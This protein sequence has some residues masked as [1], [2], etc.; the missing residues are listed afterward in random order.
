MPNTE[1]LIEEP[2]I[3]EAPVEAAATDAAEAAAAAAPGVVEPGAP[4]KVITFAV[5]CYNSAKDMDHCITSIL[6]GANYAEDIEIVIVDDG[7]NKDETPE[8]ADEWA[9]RHPGLIRAV[10][11]ENGG[12]GIAVLSGLRE[13][14]GTY[15][16]VVDSDDWLDAA[17]LSA[18][19]TMLRGFEERGTR[20]DLFISNYVYEKVY[21]GTRNAVSYK[22]VLPTK[23]IF[24]WGEIGRFH[25][26]QNLLM[27]ALCYRTDV[28]RAADVPLP[29]HTFYVDNI[30][31]YT[32]L[33]HCKTV[34]YAD[35]DLY[36]YFIGREGQSVNESTMVKRLDQQFR[37]TYI[38]MRAYH[39]YEDVE[40]EKLRAYMLNYFTMML[41]I[42]TVFS[43]L[44]DDP[45]MPGK[46][47]KL[48]DDLRDFDERM[49][50]KC[51]YSFLGLGTH[52]PTKAG[53]AITVQA[54]RIAQKIFKFN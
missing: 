16:K 1:E 32:P 14:R 42:C 26:S 24:T 5:P 43:K 33:P 39:L 8:K 19:L 22:G 28:L 41:T 10:H 51:R 52:L 36:R 11:Q 49:Y 47:V 44:S 31:A 25:L 3:A 29:A 6:E 9:A 46:A 7:S 30:Y 18:M 40:E 53:D 12:H 37:I 4:H 34:F 21:E 17:A 35:I 23:R 50:K 48:W 27:H 15:Y 13:A 54:Y 20:V 2:T 45:E 38:M